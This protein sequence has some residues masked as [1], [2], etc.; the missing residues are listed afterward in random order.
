M[1]VPAVILR[2]GGDPGRFLPWPGETRSIVLYQV[3]AVRGVSQPLSPRRSR[4]ASPTSTPEQIVAAYAKL[5]GSRSI[6]EYAVPA[7]RW[8][9]VAG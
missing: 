8:M 2:I 5:A 9:K 3:D 6:I 7:A 1:D 4:S